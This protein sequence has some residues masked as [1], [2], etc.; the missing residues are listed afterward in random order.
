MIGARH[1]HATES[2]IGGLFGLADASSASPGGKFGDPF[3]R[4]AVD[5][6]VVLT[7]S[8]RGGILLVCRSVSPRRVW[9]PSYLC[10]SMVRGVAREFGVR[11]YAVDDDL[12]ADLSFA[13][14]VHPDDVIVVLDNFGRPPDQNL[15][16][17]A[18]LRGATILEDATQSW[19]SSGAGSDSDFIVVSL[20]K[21]L[22]VPDGGVTIGRRRGVL[23]PTESLPAAPDA[24]WSTIHEACR[25]RRDYDHGPAT[26]RE[27]SAW[28]ELYRS[29]S[30][31]TPEEPVAMSSVSADL[32]RGAFDVE[33]IARRRIDNY[34]TLFEAYGR[35]ALLGEIDD[36]TVPVG[37]VCRFED[38][39][40]R[41]RVRRAL[42]DA[43]IFPPIHWELADTV[44]ARFAGS[45]TL[46][47]RILTIPCDQRYDCSDMSRI[48]DVLGRALESESTTSINTA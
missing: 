19:M 10:P 36:S 39:A 3:S 15:V 31:A 33:E 27:R 5:S 26:A 12:N 21:T 16:K 1:H 24:W 47:R 45:H 48:I 9:F 37:F 43:L 44:P 17:A 23:A 4:L 14:D 30:A 18:R 6:D 8:G 22:G 42:I 34:R 38:P 41:D 11:F 40:A 25:L 20:V 28:Y 35:L 2:V 29:A 7:A 13:V 32:I 46:S